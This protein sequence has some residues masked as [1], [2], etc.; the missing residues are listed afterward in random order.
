MARLHESLETNL[1]IERAFA[2]ISDFTNAERWD[3]G[4]VWS[5]SIGEGP[6]RIGSRYLLGVRMGGGVAEMEYRITDLVPESRVV[7]TGSGSNVEAVDDIRFERT[8]GGTRIDYLAEIKLTGW[9]R[10]VAPFIGRAFGAIAR[11]ARAGMQ[12]TL[13][14]LAGE[15]AASSTEAAA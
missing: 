3:P 9:M 13:D 12:E 5:E 1:P 15:L 4:V 8:A 11:N 14:A 10:L 6:T 7:L 2:F